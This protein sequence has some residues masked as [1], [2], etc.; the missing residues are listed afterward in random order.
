[1]ILTRNAVTLYLVAALGAGTVNT[2]AAQA[3][4]GAAEG[5]DFDT[6]AACSVVYQ[7]VGA[8]YTE[9]DESAKSVEFSQ[10][11]SA[12]AASALH[13][14]GYELTDPEQASR[15]SEQRMGDVVAALNA[16]SE[17]NPEGDMGVISEWLPYCDE[18]GPMVNQAL[19]ARDKRGW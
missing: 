7:Q 14:L 5:M 12:Y 10:A 8:L 2:A 1:M 4:G 16:A 15:Y 19:M 9:Q 13:M 17:A 11:S 6:L 3:Q 18:L